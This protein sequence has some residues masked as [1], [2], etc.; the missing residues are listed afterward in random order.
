MLAITTI[1]WYLSWG[2]L[3]VQK[4]IRRSTNE[5]LRRLLT[6]NWVSGN[7][8]ELETCKGLANPSANP[9]GYCWKLS[10]CSCLF[11]LRAKELLHRVLLSPCF[12]LFN[13]F[14][15]FQ[16]WGYLPD[17]RHKLQKVTSCPIEPWQVTRQ[18]L[19]ISGRGPIRPIPSTSNQTLVCNSIRAKLRG[20][21][22]LEKSKPHRVAPPNENKKQMK[23]EHMDWFP[24]IFFGMET[25]TLPSE[26]VCVC[27]FSIWFFWRILQGW[28]ENKNK[29][30][31]QQDLKRCVP[32]IHALHPLGF[33]WW[34]HP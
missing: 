34:E 7:S 5:L 9:K 8:L 6:S 12:F 33:F 26:C 31:H 1:W 24:P 2:H 16:L 30:T 13:E 17:L 14:R 25:E 21:L 3:F 11:D 28:K 19:G 32:L 15:Q 29:K 20:S 4:R 23:Q 22:H 27:V 10:D 18:C